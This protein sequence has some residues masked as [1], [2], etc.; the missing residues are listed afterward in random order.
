MAQEKSYTNQEFEQLIKELDI[1]KKE[2]DKLN[3]ILGQIGGKKTKFGAFVSFS[4]IVGVVSLLI[5]DTYLNIFVYQKW[6]S[7]TTIEIGLFLVSG[8][9]IWMMYLQSKVSHFQF[10]ILNSIEF[11]LNSISKR[12]NKVEKNISRK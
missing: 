4:F 7:I 3:K 11:K 1:Y 2:K 12:L 10:W 8:K 9:M 5:F 6:S